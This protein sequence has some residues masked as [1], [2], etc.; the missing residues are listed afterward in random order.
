MLR[1]VITD[2]GYGP[3]PIPYPRKC[4]LYAQSRGSGSDTA[5]KFVH[6]LHIRKGDRQDSSAFA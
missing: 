3:C 6:V 4:I 2:V 1:V 5:Y